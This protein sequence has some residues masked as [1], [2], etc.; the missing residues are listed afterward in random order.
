VHTGMGN[1]KAN[2]NR[3]NWWENA[4]AEKTVFTRNNWWENARADKSV[5]VCTDSDKLHCPRESY[6]I[7]RWS[8]G[9]L[10][11]LSDLFFLFLKHSDIFMDVETYLKIMRWLS[12]FV[13]VI[14]CRRGDPH[15][16]TF[17]RPNIPIFFVTTFNRVPF[18]IFKLSIMDWYLN[19]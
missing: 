8:I 12:L 16:I 7:L 10:N 11:E 4:R 5:F 15:M 19:T 14:F 3:N 6:H 17:C 13:I 18:R 1:A 9:H 2:E